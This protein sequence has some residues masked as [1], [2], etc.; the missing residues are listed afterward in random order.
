MI[1]PDWVISYEYVFVSHRSS[2]DNWCS[3]VR[4]SSS[5]CLQYLV[6]CCGVCVNSSKQ[7]LFPI[8]P[9]V[10]RQSEVP[11]GC[12]EAPCS[13]TL[14]HQVSLCLS[15][16]QA[17]V[18][19]APCLA[20]KPHMHKHTYTHVQSPLTSL[21]NVYCILLFSTSYALLASSLSPV[22]HALSLHSS[23]LLPSFHNPC[24]TSSLLSQQESC[25]IGLL[26]T[27]H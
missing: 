11:A 14:P 2:F 17:C 4:W 15:A 9:K 27:A 1:H 7:W 12:N 3:A 19:T 18:C 23:S 21:L 25:V 26:S 16:Q 20:T 22:L 24:A 10:M 5:L 8:W 13:S 6:L